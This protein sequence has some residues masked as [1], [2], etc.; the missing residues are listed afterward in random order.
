MIRQFPYFIIVATFMGCATSPKVADRPLE[1]NPPAKWVSGI[2]N[3]AL[4]EQMP[5]G[6]LSTFNDPKLEA[7]IA[8]AMAHNYSLRTWASLIETANANAIITGANRYPQLGVGLDSSRR[9]TRT[10]AKSFS[11]SHSLDLNLSWE[12][13]LWGRLRDQSA[14]AIADIEAAQADYR[15][16]RLSIA[17]LCAKAWFRMTTAK[18][19]LNL[20]QETL[21][22]FESNAAFIQNRFESGTSSSLDLR[23]TLA[24]AANA[25]ATLAQRQQQYD[26]DVRTLEVLLGRYPANSLKESIDLPSI[27]SNVPA[28]LPSDLLTRR[29]DILAAERRLAAA[30]RRIR[31]SKKRLLPSISLTG[32]AGTTSSDLS[33]LLDD[34]FSVW[35]IA[36]GLFQPLFQGKRLVADIERKKSIAEQAFLSYAQTILNAFQEVED[37]LAAEQYLAQREVALLEST[38]HSKSAERL[39]QDEYASGVSDIFTVLDSQRRALDAQNQYLSIRELRLNNR[40]NLYLALGGNFDQPSSSL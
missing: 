39:A 12:I 20:A 11:N 30:D 8:E 21:R 36:G 28:G 25:R 29:P 3:E 34:D 13:D 17:G 1:V 15:A 2:E 10:P 16:A 27:K 7:I 5:I 9:Q 33:D 18:A 35:N 22:I 19:Q 4:R 32:S 31:E 23:L 26:E 37:T 14:A 24:Q 6:W 40:V 38:T